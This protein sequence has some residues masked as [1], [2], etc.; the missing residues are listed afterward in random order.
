MTAQNG[1]KPKRAAS[2]LS[3]KAGKRPRQKAEK[4]LIRAQS[5][6][7][8]ERTEAKGLSSKAKEAAR[9]KAKTDASSLL[10]LGEAGGEK[11]VSF[12]VRVT[13][14]ERGEP[15]RTEVE[16]VRS[17]KKEI[18]PALDVERLTAFV[19]A[20]IGSPAQLEPVIT[21]L[22]PARRGTTSREFTKRAVS[23]TVSEVKVFREKSPGIM[24]LILDSDESFI[25]QVHFQLHGPDVLSLVADE[26]PYEMKVYSNEVTTGVS[27]LLTTHSAN[28][29][30]GVLAYTA[31]VDAPGLS[32]GLYRLIIWITLHAPI[33]IAD[34]YT[35][36]IIHVVETQ[37]SANPVPSGLNAPSIQA[38]R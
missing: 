30:K 11:R 6:T 20:C 19:K 10:A 14:D 18:I 31:Q 8:S 9:I 25:V 26:F 21:L 16:H 34:H 32:S 33:K 38:R 23:L 3:N 15:R 27:K 29:V 37:A 24:T 4:G 22:S 36:L 2:H 7:K 5:K 35:R 28:L 12:V 13:V 1:L 17:G